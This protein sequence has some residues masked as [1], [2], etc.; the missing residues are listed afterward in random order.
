[1]HTTILQLIALKMIILSFDETTND[2]KC[3]LCM[4]DAKP[5]YLEDEYWVNMYVCDST[6]GVSQLIE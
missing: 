6:V 3:V 1:M 2:P 5:A 4:L